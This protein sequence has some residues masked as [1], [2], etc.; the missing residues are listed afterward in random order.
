MKPLIV[1]AATREDVDAFAAP[2]NRVRPTMRAYVGEVDGKIVVLGGLAF[3][4]GRWFGFLDVT[5][6]VRPY[7]IHLMRWAI[8]VIESA[9]STG[10]RFI[11][12]EPDANEPK[13]KAW[14][15]RLGFAQDPRVPRAWRWKVE[16][17]CAKSLA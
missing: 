8:R 6:E 4:E 16:G 12:V 1:R 13:A 2:E 15:A 17:Q 5:D 10:V 3:F 7:R 14:L 9:R 11:Y